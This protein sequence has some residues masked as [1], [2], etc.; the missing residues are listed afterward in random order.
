MEDAPALQ[1]VLCYLRDHH[2]ATL[3]TSGDQGPWAAAVFYA[4]RGSTIYF[5][6]AP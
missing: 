1:R 5:L 6:S 2:V 3:A 4:N